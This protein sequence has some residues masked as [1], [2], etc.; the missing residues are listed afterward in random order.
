M[1]LSTYAF[2]IGFAP[3]FIGIPQFLF[4]ERTTA[5]IFRTLEEDMLVRF[6]GF[7]FFMFSF[8][9]LRTDYTV[10]T[11]IAGLVRLMAWLVTLKS[12]VLLY[13]PAWRARMVRR[14]LAQDFMRRLHGALAIGMGILLLVAAE[15]LGG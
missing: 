5:W 6:I 7:V 15:K 14:F 8:L 1:P 4:P 13:A 10:G 12:L 2:I 3:L 9:V 11:D